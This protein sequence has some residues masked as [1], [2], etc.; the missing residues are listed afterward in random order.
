MAIC[1]FYD[2]AVTAGSGN[3]VSQGIFISPSDLPGFNGSEF[4]DTSEITKE[5]KAIYALLNAVYKNTA[6]TPPLGFASI[7][8]SNPQGTGVNQST[9]SI[10]LTGQ[11]HLN[12]R[13]LI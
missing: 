13:L 6:T 5:G 11:T 12:S 3:G 9:E 1:N 4:T 2:S 10:S 8:K 7:A